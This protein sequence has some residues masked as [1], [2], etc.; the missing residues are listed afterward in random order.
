[1]YSSMAFTASFAWPMALIT[2]ADPETVI[3]DFHDEL[4][5]LLT[6]ALVPDPSPPSQALSARLDQAL[7][8]LDELLSGD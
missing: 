6:Q 2:V 7:A 8:D 1:M 3:V 4:D 5:A